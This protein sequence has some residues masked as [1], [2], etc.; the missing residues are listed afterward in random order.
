MLS[1]GRCEPAELDLFEKLQTAF[2]VGAS[3]FKPY[4]N[5]IQLKNDKTV[6]G[7][8]EAIRGLESR[9]TPHLA[10]AA[11]LLYMMSADGSLGQEEIG[12]LETVIG[13][14]DGLQK[15]ALAYV[16][17]VKREEFFRQAAPVLTTAQK[18][19]VLTNVCDSMMSDG[20]VAVVED[21]LFLS[22]MSALGI[23]VAEFD[24][25]HKVLETKNFKPFDT[26]KF[27]NRTSH[28]RSAGTANA[29]GDIFDMAKDDSQLGEYFP[30]QV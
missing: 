5:A 22:M 16:R 8:F 3:A 12:Q 2:G 25:F 10:L 30:N 13:E 14:F 1:D 26:S 18:L 17:A 23:Q 28:V 11:S 21:K 9:I 15:A 19:C 27:E 6:L 4:L 24:E 7:P 29:G 20:V